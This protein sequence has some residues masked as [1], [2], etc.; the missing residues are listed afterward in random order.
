MYTFYY[1]D[2]DTEKKIR[3]RVALEEKAFRV[4]EKLTEESVDET[5]L[6][7][8]VLHLAFRFFFLLLLLSLFHNVL[9]ERYGHS[10]LIQQAKRFGLLFKF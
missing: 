10:R 4:V 2:T 5:T 6:A 3:R 7:K 1:R 9:V 8:L